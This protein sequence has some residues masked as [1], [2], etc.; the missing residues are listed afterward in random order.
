[1]SDYMLT[2]GSANHGVVYRVSRRAF[3]RHVVGVA[4]A[5]DGSALILFDDMASALRLGG[6]GGELAGGFDRFGVMI[7]AEI[8]GQVRWVRA[9]DEDDLTELL[10]VCQSP[11]AIPFRRWALGVLKDVRENGYH[12]A[13]VLAEN[14]LIA[15]AELIIKMIRDQEATKRLAEEAKALAIGAHGNLAEVRDIA[16]SAK[17]LALGEDGF[18]TLSEYA[19]RKG[20]TPSQEIL[21]DE[22]W[23][24]AKWLRQT[25][26]K[27]HI[28]SEKRNP[29][30]NNSHPVNAYRV[31][32]LDQCWWPDFAQRMGYHR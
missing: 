25:G 3:G 12:I 9:I 30:A 23:K 17:L 32:I 6:K 5:D 20:Y 19:A 31:P 1:M 22:G 28:S 10:M 4:V 7:Q 2:T 21:K 26:Q 13:P 16:Q 11:E 14:P 27:H 15:Q 8:D 18:L 29:G 24:L